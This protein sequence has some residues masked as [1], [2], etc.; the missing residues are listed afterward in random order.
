MVK[1][2]GL[3]VDKVTYAKIEDFIACVGN[4]K[5]QELKYIGS[6]ILH[7]AINKGAHESFIDWIKFWSMGQL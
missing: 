4:C 3:G 2:E 1:W 7:G 6:K 5:L